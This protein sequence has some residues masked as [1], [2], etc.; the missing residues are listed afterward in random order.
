VGRGA[1][2]TWTATAAEVVRLPASSV[3]V[4]VKLC[5]PLLSVVVFQLKVKGGALL[6]PTEEPSAN[7]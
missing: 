7:S 1:L 2:F 3:A 5:W 4:A 6:I